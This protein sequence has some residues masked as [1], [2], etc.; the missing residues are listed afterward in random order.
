MLVRILAIMHAINTKDPKE[1][2]KNLYQVLCVPYK[3]TKSLERL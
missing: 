1:R 2:E 3:I